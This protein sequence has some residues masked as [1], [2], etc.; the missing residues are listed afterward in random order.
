MTKEL[1]ATANKH[2]H[3]VEATNPDKLSQSGSAERPHGTL[4]EQV[5]CLLRA[6]QDCESNFGP[7]TSSA[8]L[9]CA[10]GRS[11]LQST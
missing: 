11:T 7:A 8:Q 6:L 5:R 3:I 2:G 9:G 10:T 4:K 1:R